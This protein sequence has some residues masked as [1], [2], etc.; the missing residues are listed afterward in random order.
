MPADDF[1]APMKF[2]VGQPVRR[3]EDLRLLTGRGRYQD[4]WVLPRQ[5]WCIFVRLPHAQRLDPRIR[6]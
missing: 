2:G 4:D 5:A 1:P 6:Y 3:F